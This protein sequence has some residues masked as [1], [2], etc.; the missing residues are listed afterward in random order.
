MYEHFWQKPG[1]RRRKKTDSRTVVLDAAI[2]NGLIAGDELVLIP[3]VVPHLNDASRAL[4]EVLLQRRKSGRIPDDDLS[5]ACC[6]LFAKGVEAVMLWG[7]SPTGMVS[8]L[9]DRSLQI[10]AIEPTIPTCYH[11]VIAESAPLAIPLLRKQQDW[12]NRQPQLHTRSSDHLEEIRKMLEWLPLIGMTHAYQRGYDA[13][14]N[15]P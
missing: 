11:S 12:S 4:Y 3:E 13:L 14:M 15:V 9:V 10:L 6:V 5:R 8:F 1:S 2:D 7:A